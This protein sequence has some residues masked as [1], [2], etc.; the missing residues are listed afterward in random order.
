MEEKSA[1]VIVIGAGISGL[2]AAVDLK[3]GGKKVIILEA[4]D[5]VGGR[6]YTDRTWKNTSL[7]L[8]PGWIT[9]IKG[10]P[11]TELAVK[12]K[13]KTAVQNDDSDNVVLYDPEGE[14]VSDEEWDKLDSDFDE[15]ME[16]LG[17]ESE[18]L[19]KDVSLGSLI[20]KYMD[21]N[22]FSEKEKIKMRYYVFDS[23][24]TDYAMDSSELSAK[25]WN[26]D[27]GFEGGDVI[28]PNGY[29]EIAQNLS[30]GLDIRLEHTVKK[31]SYNDDGVTVETD[32]GT[33]KGDY[34]LVTLPLGVLKKG[35]VKFDPPLPKR[36]QDAVNRLKMGVM[37]RL[38]L[39]F[40]KA[41]WPKEPELMNMYAKKREDYLDMM[42]FYHY[43]DKPILLFFTAGNDAVE[44]ESL[45]DEELIQ[46]VM[47]SLKKIYGEDI[48]EPEDYIR[49]SWSKDEF[50]YGSYAYIPPG[51]FPE[52][53]DA[54]GES[55]DDVLFFAGEATTSDYS[56][57]VHGALISGREAAE[58]IL[59]D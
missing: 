21:K 6:Q 56:G 51:A 11:V 41:F 12:F 31:I 37:N 9:G 58:E 47:K 10:N 27:D 2:G 8:G 49:K 45:S 55:V 39:K 18:K 16:E 30:K 15:M 20:E 14:E 29:D 33:F 17:E 40:P 3:K 43:L 36:K 34:A 38:Y 53:H 23:I 4:R 7:D 19:E 5:R 50:S 13:L 22:D 24:E 57:T 35:T 52:D 59:S 28:F 1:D 46:S 32:Q 44:K 54:L 48:P 42:N 26:S 25:Y